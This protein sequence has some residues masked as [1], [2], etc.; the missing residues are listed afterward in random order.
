MVSEASAVDYP[1]FDHLVV[2]VSSLERASREFR[3]AGFSVVA[4]GSHGLTENALVVFQDGSYIELLA[5][6]GRFK[7]RLLR[8]AGS[9]GLLGFFARRRNDIYARFMP[10]LGAPAGPIDWCVR[11]TSLDQTVKAWEAHDI[12]CLGSEE[13]ERSLPDG[14]IAEWRLGGVEDTDLPFLLED[15]SDRMIRV[16]NRSAKHP[17]GALGIRRLTIRPPAK[18]DLCHGLRVAFGSQFSETNSG[19]ELNLGS[20]AVQFSESA[21]PSARFTVEISSVS[22]GTDPLKQLQICNTPILIRNGR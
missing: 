16:P 3:D 5:V 1:K 18:L 14:R 15:I 7:S 12:G 21:S 9:G 13:F 20:T 17:N 2:K 22:D 19:V 10:W 8:F 11:V 4:G 6:S